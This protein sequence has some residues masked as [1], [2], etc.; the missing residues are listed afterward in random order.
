MYAF[1]ES[2][3]RWSR[4]AWWPSGVLSCL[5]APSSPWVMLLSI[6]WVPTP[7]RG[8]RGKGGV[9]KKPE[10]HRDLLAAQPH[11]A[12]RQGCV[13]FSCEI[14]SLG[15]NWESCHHRKKERMDFE[16]NWQ[17][18]SQ[19][20]FRACAQERQVGQ[21]PFLTPK[22]PNLAPLALLAAPR[23]QKLGSSRMQP[24]AKSNLA[25]TSGL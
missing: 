4:L 16:D 24:S 12:A 15:K 22:P 11:Q 18:L 5:M 20:R 7:T 6:F 1:S 21:D 2:L 14:L 13:Q 10:D 3:G 19:T 23:G 17:L 25:F 9:Y 8:Q